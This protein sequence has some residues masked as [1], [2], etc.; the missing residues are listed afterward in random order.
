M[1]GNVW[2]GNILGGASGI[3]A[4]GDSVV[5]VSLEEIIEGKYSLVYAHPGAFLSISN[6]TAILSAFER[7]L[8]VSCI[9]FDES[10]MVL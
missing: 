9:A 7:D 2:G 3:P 1:G 10:H 4:K 5:I 8:T 6:G